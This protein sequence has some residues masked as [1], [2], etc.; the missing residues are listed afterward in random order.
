M[1]S[2]FQIYLYNQ[3]IDG[4]MEQCCCM[5]ICHFCLKILTFPL[6]LY[7]LLT[8]LTSAP[9]LHLNSYTYRNRPRTAFKDDFPRTLA[10]VCANVN[11]K[12]TD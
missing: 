1:A 9:S 10:V 2:A 6:Q 5:N 8:H 11:V 4:L 7:T 3:A 12:L